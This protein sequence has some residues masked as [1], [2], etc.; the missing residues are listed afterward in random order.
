MPDTA[1]TAGSSSMFSGLIKWVG[2]IAA[3]VIAAVLIYHF[4]HPT[5]PPPPVPS[6]EIYG[7]VADAASHALIANAMVVL[8]LGS[9]SVSQ[10]TDSLGKY[11][12]VLESAGTGPVMGDVKITAAGY[13]PYNN[14]VTLQPGSNFAEITLQSEQ[15]SPPIVGAAPGAAS[16]SLQLPARAGITFRPPPSGFVKRQSMVVM[17]MKQ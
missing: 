9:G 10:Q 11:N 13:Q 15:P 17:R 3:S 4:T 7:V 2:G 16:G 1:D 6:V 12:M 8:S 14:S 5:P